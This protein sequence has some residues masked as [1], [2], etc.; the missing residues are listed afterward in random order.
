MT[1]FVVGF[2]GTRHGLTLAQ[3]E[4]LREYLRALPVER[5]HHGDCIGADATAHLFMRASVQIEIHPSDRRDTRAYCK[6][7]AKVH[8]P[9]APLDRDRDIVDVVQMLV[10]CPRNLFEERRSGTWATTRYAFGKNR[11]VTIVWPDGR[12]Q[13]NATPDTLPEAT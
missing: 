11:Q 3:R 2:T 7:A 12:V 5:F 6:G 4:A 10:A 1:R 13:P 9:K 8:P